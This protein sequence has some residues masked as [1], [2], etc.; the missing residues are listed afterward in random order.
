MKYAVFSMLFMALLSFLAASVFATDTGKEGP[1]PQD[2]SQFSITVNKMIGGGA[3]GATD[4]IV[5]ESAGAVYRVKA[6]TFHDK[7]VKSL[8]RKIDQNA[9]SELRAALKEAN[10]WKLPSGAPH[11]SGN[12]WTITVKG[13]TKVIYW[14]GTI[15]SQLAKAEK[16]INRILAR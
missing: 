2:W 16:V 14:E 8:V 5:I 1:P 9:V 6:P 15:P 4:D 7:P 3:A 12:S 11:Y 13:Q 10:P